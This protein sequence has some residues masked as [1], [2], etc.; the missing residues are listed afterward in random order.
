MA[1]KLLIA[2]VI[3]AALA[4]GAFF[5]LRAQL[6]ADSPAP[7]ELARVADPTSQR[8]CRGRRGGGLRRPLRKPRLAR[9]SVRGAARRRAA[10][11]RAR[12]AGAP[13]AA[14]ARRSRSERHCPQFASLF[15]G[16]DD[17][18]SG[19]VSGSEDCLYLNVY[20]PRMDAAA[21]RAGER[22]R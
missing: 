22:C 16:V 15:G 1:R 20:A 2:L 8:G 4:G 21:C 9:H 14:P 12:A 13:G 6:S 3:L 11:A 17:V 19:I 7:P 18:E 5:F 10:L